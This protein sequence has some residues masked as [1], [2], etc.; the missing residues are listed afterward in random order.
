MTFIRTRETLPGETEDNRRKRLGREKQD[1]RKARAKGLSLEE[2]LKQRELAKLARLAAKEAKL[3][4]ITAKEEPIVSEPVVEQPEVTSTVEDV[5]EPVADEP[6]DWDVEVEAKTP[7]RP[8]WKVYDDWH[9]LPGGEKKSPPG[10]YYH[11][12]KVLK[13]GYELPY[14]N[15]VCGPLHV[16]ASSCDINQYNFGIMLRLKNKRDSWHN[17]LMPAD[18][19]SGDCGELRAELLRHGLYLNLMFKAMLPDY[20]QSQHPKQKLE[21]ALRVGWHD[22]CFV[23]PD[24]VIGNRSDIFFQSNH[25]VLAP[26]GQCGTVID[27]RNHVA[28]YCTGNSTMMFQTSCGFAGPLLEKCNLDY[29]GVHI[30]NDSSTG[31]T[32]GQ[33]VACSVWGSKDFMKTWNSTAN[34]LEAGAAMYNNVVLPLDELSNS[35]AHEVSKTLYMLGNG[36]GK[37]RANVHGTARQVQSWS[38]IL[39]SNGERTLE[40]HLKEKGV[41]VKAGQAVRFL[42]FPANGT[43]G[44]FNDLHELKT[45]RAFADTVKA[46]ARNY[47]GTAGIAF[48]ECLVNDNRD[49]GL[50]HEQAFALFIN[51][52][53]S[54]QENRA[55]TA[56][57]LVGLAGEIATEYGITGWNVGDAMKASLDCFK[58]WREFRGKG[59]SEDAKI[60]Q[61]IREYVERYGD[62][63]FTATFESQFETGLPTNSLRSTVGQIRS[64]WYRTFDGQQQWLFQKS[65]LG[66]ATVG[67]NYKRVIT[68]L[69]KAGWLLADSEGKNSSPVRVNGDLKRV[70]IIT[71]LPAP[72]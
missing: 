32:T 21:C 61:M 34:G 17:W 9:V 69:K 33:A 45:G 55:A 51:R 36:I 71:I 28:K 38:L 23:L 8:Y 56:F 20:L 15:H 68:A 50:L 43:Y 14:D 49:F 22:D 37:M 1:K 70:I 10:V 47:Y 46:N 7:S 40:D 66:D 57:A 44:S 29:V 27:W 63:R 2:Y 11:G 16:E 48:L 67:F 18:M 31:K 30:F 39:L 6:V 64:G 4:G 35:E 52:E 72:H 62:S 26:F 58:A 3:A 24:R 19:L 53:L 41:S 5:T 60:L 65:G 13:N 12:V 42:E 25:S 54:S 59:Q